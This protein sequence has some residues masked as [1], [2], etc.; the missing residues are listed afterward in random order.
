MF[1]TSVV[2]ISIVRS[3]STAE[4]SSLFSFGSLNMNSVCFAT[5]V[6][7]GSKCSVAGSIGW[8]SG[9]A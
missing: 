6:G 2:S 8:S 4:G 1:L 3:S 5:Q 9:S 7:K